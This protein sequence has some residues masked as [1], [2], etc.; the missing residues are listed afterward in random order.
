MNRLI[1]Q[2]HNGKRVMSLSITQGHLADIENMSGF[3]H[4]VSHC[5]TGKN[6]G[7]KCP[8]HDI[9]WDLFKSK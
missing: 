1:M 8:K 2:Y 4:K 6:K 5:V 7:K 3:Y 9:E